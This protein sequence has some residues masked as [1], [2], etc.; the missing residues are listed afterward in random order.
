[1]AQVDVY[2][3]AKGTAQAARLLDPA[4]AA[5][6]IVTLID[7][8]RIG[9]I[10]QSLSAVKLTAPQARILNVKTGDAAMRTLR[11]YFNPANKLMVVAD[12]LYRG[13]LYTYMSTLH[14]G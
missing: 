8:S 2:V 7:A 6:Q 12:S 4:L 9:R 13:D 11:H 1:M 10:E 3:S 5:R 14:R